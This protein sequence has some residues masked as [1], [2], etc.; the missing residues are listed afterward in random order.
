MLED[1]KIEP[2]R[3][4]MIAEWPESTYHHNIQVFLGFAN[5]YRH[6]ISSFL[7]LAKRM[8]DMLKRE[9]NGCL[10]GPF[11]PTPAMKWSFAE[12]CN[13]FTEALVLAHFDPAKPVCLETNASGFPIASIISQQQDE[14]PGGTEGAP[15][16]A[17][18]NKSAS[19]GY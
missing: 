7:H 8:T 5:F 9:R 2:D 16:G 15:H 13:A 10:L 4:R 14:V 1:V 19:K 3:V 6:F 18:G 12:L 17:K 11:L